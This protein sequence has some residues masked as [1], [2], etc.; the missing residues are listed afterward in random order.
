VT[1]CPL[2]DAPNATDRLRQGLTAYPRLAT[3]PPED[4]DD[5][6]RRHLHE[7][8]ELAEG[9]L[10]H[11]GGNTLVHFD[12]RADNIVLGNDGRVWFVDWPWACRGAI[13][14]D[15]TLFLV[16]AALYGH[17]PQKYAER[18]PLLADVDPWHVTGLLAG[19]AGM[20]AEE[21]RQP[22]PPGIPTLRAFQRAQLDVTLP[23]IRRRTG[24]E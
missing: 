12:I 19:L 3:A 9:T 18:H 16:N 17:D 15:I 21:T 14:M 20:W 22:A 10:A 6:E 2:D 8:A 4:L 24:W 5:W 1:P 13:W 11:I 23:W 7:L